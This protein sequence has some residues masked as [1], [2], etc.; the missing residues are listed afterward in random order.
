[1]HAALEVNIANNE[2]GCANV[3]REDIV[4]EKSS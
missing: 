2:A 4:E 3:S 1:M